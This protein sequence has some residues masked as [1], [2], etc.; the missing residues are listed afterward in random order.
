MQSVQENYWV[1][2]S[3]NLRLLIVDWGT[4]NKFLAKYYTYVY[5]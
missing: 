2:L 4:L 1:G 5:T 3:A